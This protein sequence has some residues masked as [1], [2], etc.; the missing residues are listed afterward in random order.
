MSGRAGK[1]RRNEQFREVL[2]NGRAVV[3]GL[4]VIYVLHREGPRLAGVTVPRRFGAAV[5]RNR[6]RRL[7][8]EAYRASER[9][10][11]DDCRI[12]M[13][14]RPRARGQRY[15]AI[16]NSLGGLFRRADLYREETGI[17]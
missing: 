6:V 16:L 5:A 9:A 8:W 3:H 1:L 2:G 15:A 11:V 17:S 14:P 4:A 12:V 13:I 7:F 10:L